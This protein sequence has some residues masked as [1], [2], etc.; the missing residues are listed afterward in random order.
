MAFIFS[1]PSTDYNS[2]QDN[3]DNWTPENWKVVNEKNKDDGGLIATYLIQ[4]SETLHCC[5]L[6]KE[7]EDEPVSFRAHNVLEEKGH[8]L[9]IL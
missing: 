5:F 3:D 9:C 2:S 1:V 8:T 7:A 4:F 6:G